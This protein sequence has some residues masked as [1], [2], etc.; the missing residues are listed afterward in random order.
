MAA[1]KCPTCGEFMQEWQWIN[2][3]CAQELVAQL[4]RNTARE[5]DELEIAEGRYCAYCGMRLRW[6][7][8]RA[9]LYACQTCPSCGPRIGEQIKTLILEYPGTEKFPIFYLPAVPQWQPEYQI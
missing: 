5:N 4:A 9:S 2:H 3:A 1:I 7:P 8:P 6:L